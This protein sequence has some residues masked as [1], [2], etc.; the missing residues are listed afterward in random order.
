MGYYAANSGNFLSTFQDNLSGL[1]FRGLESKK[2]DSTDRLS[3]NVDNK[4]PLLTV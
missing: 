3:W 1:I 2:W 4:L